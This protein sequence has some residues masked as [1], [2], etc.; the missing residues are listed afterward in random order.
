M[1]LHAVADGD[2]FVLTGTKRHVRFASAADALVVLARTGPGATDI[3]LFLVTARRAGRHAHA[4][5][6]DRVR[7]AVPGRLRRRARA[8]GRRA[9]APA[10]SGWATWD[11]TMHDGII[12]L[13][14]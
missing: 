12:L 14:A 1:Q 6:D 7:H 5:D 8:G 4:A 11:A 10:G 3:D 2:G 9:S 13:A